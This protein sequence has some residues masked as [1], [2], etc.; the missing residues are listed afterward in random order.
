MKKSLI[1]TVTMFL[2]MMIIFGIA[3]A[4]GTLDF[5]TET[6]ETLTNNTNQKHRNDFKGFVNPFFL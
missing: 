1:I 2:S 4:Y 6:N 5:K 3:F